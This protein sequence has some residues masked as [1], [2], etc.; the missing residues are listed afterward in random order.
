MPAQD[1]P[2]NQAMVARP[3]GRVVG[4]IGPEELRQVGLVEQAAIFS[5]AVKDMNK[6]DK[7]PM[8]KKLQYMI[9]T[10]S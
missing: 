3:P 9:G 1:L 8:D 7:I 2:P 6:D 5:Y 4:S 10:W